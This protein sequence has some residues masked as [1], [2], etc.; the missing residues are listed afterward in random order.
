MPAGFREQGEW[1]VFVLT[2]ANQAGVPVFAAPVLLAV[3]A[4]GASGGMHITV[5]VTVAICGALC[6]DLAWYGLGKWRGTWALAVLR[7]HSVRTAWLLDE[8]ER[9]VLAHD[10]ALQLIARF[11]PELNPIAAALAGAA[12]VRLARFVV[13]ATASAAVWAGTWIGVGYAIAGAWSGDAWGTSG[14]AAIVVGSAIV[15]LTVTIRAVLG[16]SER[17]AVELDITLNRE[18]E[19]SA[20]KRA[21]PHGTGKG[22]A[23]ME[24]NEYLFETV[25]RDRL[26]QMREDAERARRLRAA[27]PV[28]RSLQLALGHALIRIGRRLQGVRDYSVARIEAGGAVVAPRRSTH[29]AHG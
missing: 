26:A 15:S 9:L 14:V 18:A 7:R 1:I 21:E 29:G 4:L 16:R 8:A 23:A 5:L 13:G 20:T 27:R 11:L 19:S 28:S 12:R 10:R 17:S 25:A 24:M 3:G 22:V 6:A 2:L